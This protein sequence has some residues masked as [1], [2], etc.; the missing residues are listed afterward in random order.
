MIFKPKND[1][2]IKEN[3]RDFLIDNMAITSV[4]YSPGSWRDK[5]STGIGT[6]FFR[7]MKEK[8]GD[9]FFVNVAE[10][11][12]EFLDYLDHKYQHVVIGKNTLYFVKPYNLEQ[13]VDDIIKATEELN[14]IHGNKSFNGYFVQ[15]MNWD[16][17][18][19]NDNKLKRKYVFESLDDI[20]KPKSEKQIIEEISRDIYLELL[21][22]KSISFFKQQSTNKYVAFESKWNITS[23]FDRIYNLNEKLSGLYLFMSV[24]EK[25]PLQHIFPY[26]KVAHYD[27]L[28][29]FDVPIG[30]LDFAIKEIVAETYKTDGGFHIKYYKD[31]NI[32]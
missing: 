3:I 28:F 29:I 2:E 12:S 23:E 21:E 13:L 31:K 30:K 18:I 7:Q 17:K 4:N 6:Q 15:M 1:K 14:E 11:I 20:L 19:Q 16:L 22:D 5:L 10:S 26:K 24:K 8:Y 27:G 9:K 32:K 25:L